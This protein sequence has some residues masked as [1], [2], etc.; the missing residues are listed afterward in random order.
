M[1]VWPPKDSD[2]IAIRQVNWSRHPS[3]IAGDTIASATFSLATPAGMTAADAEHNSG[4]LSQVTLSGGTEGAKGKVLCGVV[5]DEGQT[6][7][8]TVTILIQSR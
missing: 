8:Q 3:W 1:L 5:T 4:T 2:E 6:L 7:Q